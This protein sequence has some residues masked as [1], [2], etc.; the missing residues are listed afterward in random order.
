MIRVLITDDHPVMR[1]GLRA[2]ISTQADMALAGEA[3][4]GREA[5]EK[6][7]ELR[8]SVALMDLQM[9]DVDGLDAISAIRSEFPD[10]NIIVLTSYPGDARIMRALMLGATSYLLKSS[11]LEEIVRAIRAS[12]AGRHVMDPDVAHDLAAY[13]GTELLTAKEVA[14]LALVAQG[15][16]N[17]MIAG[18][19]FVSEE[20]VKSRMRSILSKLNARDRTH[21][22][23]LA[24]QRGFLQP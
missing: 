19:L 5:I 8:P 24:I 6:F 17:K 18:E 10:A 21:A 13:A 7:R 2:A 12:M 3:A 20:T 1:H 22:V 15:H 4:N 16:G 23:M 11:S 9:P 14:V